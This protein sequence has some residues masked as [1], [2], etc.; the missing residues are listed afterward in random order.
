MMTLA[1][2]CRLSVDEIW[3]HIW[4]PIYYLLGYFVLPCSECGRLFSGGEHRSGSLTIDDSRS[5][6]TCSRKDCRDR[7]QSKNIAW[8]GARC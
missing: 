5:V 8:R 2:V 1:Q 4:L 6:M 3:R 7:V